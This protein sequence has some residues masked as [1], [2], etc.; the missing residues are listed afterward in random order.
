V[1]NF[2][3]R[4]SVSDRNWIDVSNSSG[5][6][7]FLFLLSFVE[8]SWTEFFPCHPESCCETCH[9]GILT[10]L[11]LRQ[12]SLASIDSYRPTL[13]GSLP[14]A[15]GEA[16]PACPLLLSTPCYVPLYVSDF[17]FIF[18]ICLYL[19]WPRSWLRNC[20]M[21]QKVAVSI[22]R[23]CRSFSLTQSFRPHCDIGA[24]SVFNRNEYQ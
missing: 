14:L 20:T 8:V 3:Y 6:L 19:V 21:N 1:R 13:T 2:V 12:K 16:Q 17:H 4:N 15:R 7:S 18:L 23:W 24:D 22:P 11:S 9:C 5:L 10:V